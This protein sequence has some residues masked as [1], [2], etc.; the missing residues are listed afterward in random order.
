MHFVLYRDHSNQWR[1]TLYAA[2]NKK[3]A[4]SGESYWNKN[5]A[6]NGINL[7]MSTNHQTPVYER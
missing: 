3:V 6:I 7:V 2:N 5:D 4:D 1:W